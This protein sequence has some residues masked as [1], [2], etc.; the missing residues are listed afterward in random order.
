MAPPPEEGMTFHDG[1][2]AVEAI[3]D[4]ALSIKKRLYQRKNS[5]AWYISSLDLGHMNCT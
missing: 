3:Q 1:S 4:Y 2:A 5:N